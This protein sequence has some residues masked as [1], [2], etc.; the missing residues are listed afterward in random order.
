MSDPGASHELMRRLASRAR[1]LLGISPKYGFSTVDCHGIYQSDPYYPFEYDLYPSLR[2]ATPQ[3]I[4]ISQ[5][6]EFSL[7]LVPRTVSRNISL[8]SRNPPNYMT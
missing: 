2:G 1:R 3:T 8:G 5:S 4:F 6:E 7:K